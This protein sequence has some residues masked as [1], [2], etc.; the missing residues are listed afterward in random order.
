M[1]AKL[2]NQ[3]G[4][5]MFIY[6][7]VKTIAQTK[8]YSFKY[9]LGDTYIVNSFDKNYG[10]TIYSIFPNTKQDLCE[11]LPEIYD[12]YNE[13][14]E[15]NRITNYNL[16]AYDVLD[17]TIMCGLFQSP[18]YFESNKK[19][20]KNW[21]MFPKEIRQGAISKMNTIKEQYKGDNIVAIHFRQGADYQKLGY[22]IGK[23]YYVNAINKITSILGDNCFFVLLGDKL[24]KN[25][26]RLFSTGNYCNVRG[27]LAE[28]LCFLSMCNN[29]IISNSTFA[30]WGAFLSDA[31]IVIRPS[32][33]YTFGTSSAP[34][35][36]FPKEWISVKATRST[37]AKMSG[38]LLQTV[39]STRIKIKEKCPTL[40]NKV[41]K[42][43]YKI[44]G[45]KRTE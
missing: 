26:S 25:I 23:K 17:N 11:N 10:N 3:L 33:F 2:S 41:M 15:T 27:S 12:I 13:P 34:S 38:I 40:Y 16:D 1:I 9:I 35:D 14:Y 4:N 6:A 22:A 19:N 24:P 32:T 44:A 42:Y 28:D 43:I 36:I 7:A 45:I 31:N 18:L 30:W 37:H 21:F 39:D 20:V 29:L 5:Q 8:N